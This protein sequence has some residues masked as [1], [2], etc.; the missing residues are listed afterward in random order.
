MKVMIR[1]SQNVINRGRNKLYDV[2]LQSPA[3]AGWEYLGT[4]DQGDIDWIK[5]AWEKINASVQAA[6]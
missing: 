6:G 3:R 2:W 4:Y 5:G 1:I